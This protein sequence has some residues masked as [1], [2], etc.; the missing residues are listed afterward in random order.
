M[1]AFLKVRQDLIRVILS[2]RGPLSAG[3]GWDERGERVVQEEPMSR[4]Y[5]NPPT[6][7]H[8]ERS[9]G[10]QYCGMRPGTTALRSPTSVSEAPL[11]RHHRQNTEILH[12]LRSFRMT[13]Q[14]RNRLLVHEE[15]QPKALSIWDARPPAAYSYGCAATSRIWR[16]FTA[17]SG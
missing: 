10:S 2:I 17:F 16:S 7:G 11:P 14:K 6:K 1:T 12:S 3:Y 9:E 5:P 4:I 15:S 13:L 8:P